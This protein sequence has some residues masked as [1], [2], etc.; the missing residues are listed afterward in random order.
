[1]NFIRKKLI[2]I[3]AFGASQ[4]IV[5]QNHDSL[6]YKAQ[7]YFAD[8]F[9]ITRV[10]NVEYNQLS[11][12]KFDSKLLDEDTQDGKVKNY[13]QARVSANINLVKKPKWALGTILNYRY[14]SI[15]TESSAWEKKN[16]KSDFNFHSTAVNFTY[17]SQLMGKTMLYSASTIVDG[18]DK[19]FERVKGILSATMILKATPE[20]KMTVGLVAIVDPSVQVPVIP[21]FSYEH[22]FS[23]NWTLDFI[24]PQRLLVKKNILENGRLSLGSEL[25]GTSFYL[26]NN[27]QKYELR[28]M[29]I[30]SGATYEH[31][32]GKSMVASLKTGI[33]SI[34]KSRIFEKNESFDSYIIEVKPSASFYI[35][36]GFS[37]NPF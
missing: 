22:R 31:Y 13:Y 24:F 8:K 2:L 18:S 37:F 11:P 25:D 32:L 27:S 29:E 10:F 26:Y 6:K 36:L 20:T 7:A 1:M 14:T 9:P 30:N 4:L 23:N 15:T 5:A 12:Y 21:T 3:L 16:K 17:F 35:N 34:P 28:Q 19:H 33:K